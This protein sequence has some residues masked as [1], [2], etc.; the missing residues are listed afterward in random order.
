MGNRD[1]PQTYDVNLSGGL[2]YLHMQSPELS[3]R[4]EPQQVFL[5]VGIVKCVTQK[6]QK[7]ESTDGFNSA[8]T[9]TLETLLVFSFGVM[10][11]MA[12]FWWWGGVTSRLGLSTAVVSPWDSYARWTISY[13]LALGSGAVV[14]RFALFLT[15]DSAIALIVSTVLFAALATFE[16]FR[17]KRY[18]AVIVGSKVQPIQ[19]G[20]LL[21]V[22]FALALVGFI[23]NTLFYTP[24]PGSLSAFDGLGGLH[25]VRYAWV[26]AYGDFCQA[27]PVTGQNS[28]QST[29]LMLVSIAGFNFPLIATA[30]LLSVNLSILVVLVF[31]LL[32]QFGFTTAASI[33]GTMFFALGGTALSLGHV[34]VVDSGYP[35]ALNGYVDTSIAVV[36]TLLILVLL[37]NRSFRPETP[38]TDLGIVESLVVSFILGSSLAIMAPQNL[39]F[40]AVVATWSTFRFLVAGMTQRSSFGLSF[41]SGF[42]LSAVATTP[43]GTMF[44]PNFLVDP[45]RFNGVMNVAGDETGLTM[46]L[47]STNFSVHNQGQ[48]FGPSAGGRE[49]MQGWLE[50]SGTDQVESLSP[51]LPNVVWALEEVFWSSLRAVGITVTVLLLALYLLSRNRYATPRA[52]LFSDLS[53]VGLFALLAGLLLTTSFRY[54]GYESELA[55]FL[56]PASI[57]ASFVG[58]FLLACGWMSEKRRDKILA[59][60]FTG[61]SITGPAVNFIA[62]ALV[63]GGEVF[64]PSDSSILELFLV[65]SELLPEVVGAEFECDL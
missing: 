21:G 45:I 25:N 50:N 64:S 20:R 52:R 1:G 33:L 11:F 32:K 30:V 27:F 24:Q 17:A 38:S 5:H 46:R 18:P 54:N 60:V 34:H 39:I 47:P 49:Q 12:S 36:L 29:L 3:E 58:A 14:F 23:A 19:L 53:T 48:Y 9:P 57:V 31:S 56:L 6:P 41:F 16:R 22:I 43:L 44:T 40:L 15:K 55:R 7:Q 13:F 28:G 8:M 63:S 37:I 35:I 4:P 65:S 26:A 59:F 51:P 10:S 62:T 2:K 61:I 42:L